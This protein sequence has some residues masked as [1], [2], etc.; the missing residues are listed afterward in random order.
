MKN[1]VENIPFYIATAGDPFESTKAL[2]DSTTGKIQ[3]IAT[4]IFGLVVVA[5]GLLY[6]FGGR[7]MKGWIKKKW[8]DVF[9]AVIV[10]YGGTMI[11]TFIVQFVKNNGFNG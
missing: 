11:I 4:V 3:L 1:F 5:T 10:V 7:E 8:L 2:A 6:S 9:I